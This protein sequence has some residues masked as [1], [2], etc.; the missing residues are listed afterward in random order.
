MRIGLQTFILKG[1]QSWRVQVDLSA[2][3]A[4]VVNTA[5]TDCDYTELG[6]AD[7]RLSSRSSSSPRRTRR[8][9]SKNI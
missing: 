3:A 5:N 9:P 2:T 6:R 1:E 4:Y 8:I 7:Y